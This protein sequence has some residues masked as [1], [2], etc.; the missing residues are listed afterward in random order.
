MTVAQTRETQIVDLKLLFK[1]VFKNSGKETQIPIHYR[2]VLKWTI[3]DIE[4]PRNY[5]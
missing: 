2:R 1:K 4:R 3:N 5:C